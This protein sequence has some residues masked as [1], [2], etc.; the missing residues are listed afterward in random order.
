VPKIYFNFLANTTMSDLEI[1]L[2]EDLSGYEKTAVPNLKLS[3]F[4]IKTINTIAGINVALS[5]PEKGLVKRKKSIS[6][7]DGGTINL[8]IYE[9]NK[10]DPEP[11]PC[12]VYY[13]GGAFVLRD[14]G[15]MHK[16]TC[17]YALRAGCK[18]IFVHYR[19]APDYAATIILEDCYTSLEWVKNHSQELGIDPTRIAVGGDSAG[20]ALAA[21][22][23]QL[24][25][26]RKG[27]ALCFQMLIY[28]VT[29]AAQQTESVRKFINTPGWNA[30]LNMQMWCYYL[31]NADIEMMKYI[32]PISNP[33]LVN[34]P[35]SYI[36]VEEWDCLRDEGIAYAKK[37]EECGNKVTLN[38]LKGTFHGFDINLNKSIVQTAINA[39]VAAL[40]NAFEMPT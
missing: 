18:I 17:A 4:L 40:R 26:D 35:A 34:L 13:H 11:S 2:H 29:D 33:S 23:T 22:I 8:T 25:R 31:K 5:R 21:A 15:Y 36:E 14:F 3:P 24:A 38:Y 28:P 10:A 16:K 19:L 32:S 39:R 9:P 27:P 7:I 12:L 30:N 1:V 6:A 20:G 37:L